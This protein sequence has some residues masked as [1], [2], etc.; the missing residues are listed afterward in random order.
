MADPGAGHPFLLL[1]SWPDNATT[2]WDE[3][4]AALHGAGLRTVVPSL[5]GFGATRFRDAGVPPSSRVATSK[6]MPD[7]IK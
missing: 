6:I 7:S 2:T 3:V 5:R 1:R 4:L